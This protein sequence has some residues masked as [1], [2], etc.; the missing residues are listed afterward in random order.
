M[1]ELA[2]RRGTPDDAFATYQVLFAAVNDL[3]SRINA[4]PIPGDA[5]SAYARGEALHRHMAESAAE[6]WVARHPT[7]GIVGYARS[8]EHG[9]F[10]ELTEFFVLPAHQ[11]SGVGRQLLERA[12]PEGR[13][14]LRV[15][16]ASTDLR[17]LARYIKA[18]MTA[19]TVIVSVV[20]QPVAPENVPRQEGGLSVEPVPAGD[21][22]LEEVR[23]IDCDA[24]G[25]D[26]EGDLPWLATHR[27]ALLFRRG[28][29][30]V[31][32]AFVAKGGVGPIAARD[33][34]TL[35]EILDEVLRRSA[36]AG[37]ETVS[38]EAPMLNGTA[39]RHLLARGLKLDPFLT[40]LLSN[41]EFGRM[42]R[43]IAYSPPVFL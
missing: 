20:G 18:G 14:D 10:F 22:W 12:F 28:D 32:Y 37:T 42:D 43:Y 8:I 1:P 13:G 38:F 19:R 21:P 9:S 6:F 24:A 2:I 41:R 15:I 16:V 35:P 4:D 23:A 31:G 33:P 5:E 26:R 3:A 25:V 29:E 34:A 40:L 30:V 39:L 17:A 7:D 36:A 11:S 27:E